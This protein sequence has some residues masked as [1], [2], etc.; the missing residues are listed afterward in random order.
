MKQ[1]IGIAALLVAGAVAGPIVSD[2]HAQS[3]ATIVATSTPVPVP[4]NGVQYINQWSPTG[5]LTVTA[6]GSVTFTNP[7]V[8]PHTVFFGD[9]PGRGL[10]SGASETFTA[11][12][13]P[14]PVTYNC[15]LHNGMIGVLTVVAAPPTPTPNPTP[16]PTPDAEPDPDH[17]RADRHAGD[18]AGLGP[19]DVAPDLEGDGPVRAER[20][21]NGDRAAEDPQRNADPQEGH[22]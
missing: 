2:A 14:G 12:S 20:G 15:T 10:P 6:G 11:P 3:S 7:S 17:A 13:T 22:P 4:P 16:T 1:R 9:Q 21:R 5:G 19:L 8:L 18:V